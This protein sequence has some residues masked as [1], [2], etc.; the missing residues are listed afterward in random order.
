MEVIPF[1]TE[2]PREGYSTHII[3]RRLVV[4][5]ARRDDL[6]MVLFH[7]SNKG[8]PGGDEY[9]RLPK[10]CRGK[11]DYVPVAHDP[12]TGFPMGYVNHSFAEIGKRKDYH[13]VLTSKIT[14][15][16]MLQ[17]LL[18]K[19]M[20]GFHPTIVNYWLG[21]AL[22]DAGLH[23]FK[24]S[25][26]QTLLS[27]GMYWN[28][29]PSDQLISS[30]MKLMRK[31]LAP[32][33]VKQFRQRSIAIPYG[34]DP[35]EMD[36]VDSY[37]PDDD[38]VL[39]YGGRPA[40]LKRIDLMIKVTRLLRGAGIPARLELFMVGPEGKGREVE[41]ASSKFEFVKV[42]WNRPIAEYYAMCKRADACLVPSQT[43]TYG[44]SY[45][46]QMYGGALPIF[47]KRDWVDVIRPPEYQHLVDTPEEAAAICKKLYKK[48]DTKLRKQVQKWVGEAH[49]Q[50]TVVNR[51]LNL[52]V[53]LSRSIKEKKKPQSW[54]AVTHP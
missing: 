51:V 52:T 3:A 38:F 41:E 1:C 17:K 5:A 28:I 10:D 4:N 11:I 31:W 21:G 19:P 43:D 15:A 47:W 44:V 53:A 6:K 35:S 33:V 45:V 34:F 12:S 36:P 54:H 14:G 27:L 29:L 24:A 25:I 22:T 49:D 30:V 16:V 13:V 23:P 20:L 48:G 8:W 26:P 39:I 50:D 9:W 18:S 7:P 37:P 46:E 32:S 40:K 2:T 42:Y